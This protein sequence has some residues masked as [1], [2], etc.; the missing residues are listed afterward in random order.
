MTLRRDTLNI[1]SPFPPLRNGIADYVAMLSPYFCE[2]YNVRAVSQF[3][4]S[5]IDERM[6][7]V[8][9]DQFFRFQ[10][11]KDIYLHQIGNNPDHRF[12]IDALRSYGGTTTIH[13]QNII[14][15]YETINTDEMLRRYYDSDIAIAHHFGQTIKRSGAKH[16]LQYQL[17]DALGEVLKLSD[18]V[19]VHSDFAYQ[20][21]LR[22][23]GERLASKLSVIPHF[24][25]PDKTEG[26][27]KCRENLGVRQDEFLVIT[28]GFATYAK[29]FD[30][31]VEALDSIVSDFPNLRWVHAGPERPEEYNLSELI[32][33]HPRVAA[34]ATVTGYLSDDD[35]TA[36]IASSDL[37]INLRF[38]S[39]GESSGT[40]AR[41]FSVGACCVVS[42][43]AAYR[44]IPPTA[45]ARVSPYD[46][47]NGVAKTLRSLLRNRE[48]RQRLR[49]GALE[50]AS[51]T[52]IKK[53][54]DKYVNVFDRTLRLSKLG[55][56]PSKKLMRQ[57]IRRVFTCDEWPSQRFD[58]MREIIEYS[59]QGR[60]IEIRVEFESAEEFFDAISR[61]QFSLSD[62]IPAYLRPSKTNFDLKFDSH[63]DEIIKIEDEET[64]RMP[65]G[66]VAIQ[67]LLNFDAS[68][69]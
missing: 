30:W 57:F 32:N 31:L 39:V 56:S 19:I 24:C 12:V 42:D 60:I 52:S 51:Q 28:S 48:Q 21:I 43:T 14:Y 40:M 45:A 62:F 36:W 55:A 44:E 34:R 22:C 64:L 33:R 1:F 69:P 66:T 23:Y 9:F 47:V 20:R 53:C 29:R 27:E 17:F 54:A 5:I 10:S 58:L 67:V 7:H 25:P 3:I 6:E 41:A 13:D 4:N 50:F 26:Y 63:T 37:L 2:I 59:N 65:S 38:P 68:A 46:G 18:A 35:L 16:R 8:E 15:L 61:E 11:P 49:E